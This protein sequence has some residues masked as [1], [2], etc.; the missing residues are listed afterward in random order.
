MAMG[1]PTS[2]IIERIDELLAAHDPAEQPLLSAMADGRLSRD[3]LRS[4]ATQYYHLMEALPRMVSTVHS[5]TIDHISIRRMLLN[6]LVPLELNPPSVAELWLHTCASIGLFSDSVRTSR[7]T[8][9]T[10][11]CLGDFEYLC[12]EGSAQ[13]LAALYAWMCRLPQVCRIEQAAFAQHYG[14]VEGPG[15]RFFEVVAFQTQSHARGLRGALGSLVSEFPEA[16]M[17]AFEAAR[18]AVIA[19]EGMYMGALTHAG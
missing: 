5:V 8:S 17:A 13:G 3:E 19:V 1:T 9:A 4:F 2:P 10:A 11:A 15:V 14:L 18:S 12:R 6:I 16:E 7:T